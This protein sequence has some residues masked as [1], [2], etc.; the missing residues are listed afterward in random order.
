MIHDGPR[1]LAGD[2]LDKRRT[3]RRRHAGY[4]VRALITQSPPRIPY[5]VEMPRAGRRPFYLLT[6]LRD[7]NREYL[8]RFRFLAD[9][10][11]DFR[12]APTVF[13]APA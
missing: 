1:Y 5:P 9:Q 2:R 6:Q 7:F 8:G 3:H 4:D 10:F 13:T 12:E 11:V